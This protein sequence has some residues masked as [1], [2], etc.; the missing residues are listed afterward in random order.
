MDHSLYLG[1]GDNKSKYHNLIQSNVV[2]II[3]VFERL[4]AV[5]KQRLA[6]K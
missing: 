3:I 4:N 1:M 2:G 6:W 5:C